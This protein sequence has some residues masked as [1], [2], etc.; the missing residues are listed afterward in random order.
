ML[1]RDVVYADEGR[2]QRSIDDENER[3]RCGGDQG[4]QPSLDEGDNIHSDRKS[5]R[6][7]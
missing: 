5:Q 7:K 1:L 4:K 2:D 6:L 3:Q